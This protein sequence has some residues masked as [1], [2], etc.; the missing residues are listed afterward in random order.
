MG[1]YQSDEHSQHDCR[2][3]HHTFTA[4]CWQVSCLRSTQ[5]F[6][7]SQVTF[8]HQVAP[9]R[10]RLATIVVV[11]H[12]MGVYQS[13]EHS[14]HDCRAL[15]HT[16]TAPCWQVSCLRSQFFAHSQ[17]TFGHQVAPQRCRLA[18]IVVVRHYMGEYHTV[19]AIS[20]WEEVTRSH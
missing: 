9:Q 5:F 6:A 15:H 10:C 19:I 16:F 7:H 18:T 13:D 3:L 1:V 4:P 14:Q 2:A 8:G 17:V 20:D 12:C 11:W